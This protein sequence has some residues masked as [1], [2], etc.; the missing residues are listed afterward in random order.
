MYKFFLVSILLLINCTINSV[1]DGKN[2]IIN[3]FKTRIQKSKNSKS[4]VLLVHSD[5]LKLDIKSSEGFVDDKTK[6]I[7]EQ[8]FHIASVGKLLTSVM[9]FQLI[10]EDKLTLNSKI[11]SILDKK[12]LEG[13]FTIEGR[14]Y[15]SEVTIKNLLE[16][17]SGIDDYFDSIDKK[18]KSVMDE[19]TEKPDKFWTPN[20]LLD[21]TRNNQK[22]IAKPGIKFHYSD[23]GYILLGLVI[24]KISKKKLEDFALEKIFKPLQMNHTYYH[25]RSKPILDSDLKLSPIIL[26]KVDVTNYTSVS[27]DWAGG[28]I[29][30]T[31]EDLL[32]FFT[33]IQK[34]KLLN[35]SIYKSMMDRFK[36]MDGIYYGKGIMSVNFTEMSSFMP[37]T[38]ILHGHS[39]VLGTLLFYCPEL[40]SYIIA[41]FGSSLD[42]DSSFEMM[43]R[44]TKYLSEIKKIQEKK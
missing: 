36:F 3:E 15:S 16:H 18:N 43:F 10:D 1:E 22:T 8:P 30:S 42:V 37:Q 44:I 28:G 26:G 33:A 27:C 24:E 39:G 29:I 11:D 31:T 32:K 35:E 9:I 12:T 21:F 41:N 19:L 34:G 13:L 25:L 17:T 6:T 4:G 5:S 38:P 2:K 40:D 20:D 23:S 14:D 7:P